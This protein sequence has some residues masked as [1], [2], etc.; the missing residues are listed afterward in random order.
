MPEMRLAVLLD[1]GKGKDVVALELGHESVRGLLEKFMAE[2]LQRKS[3]FTR[4]EAMDAHK[5]A[6]SA[7]EKDFKKRT[8][9]I[10]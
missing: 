3:M 6:W 2:A 1:I 8:T 9:R 10:P 7:L 5:A 4:M